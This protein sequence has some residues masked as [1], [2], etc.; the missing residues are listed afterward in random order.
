L[1]LGPQAGV[2]GLHLIAV[3]IDTDVPEEVA[4]IRSVLPGSP[5]AKRGAKGETQF[6]LAPATVVSRPYNDAGKRRML[7]LLCAGRQ[8]VMVPSIH[9][10]TGKPYV[11]ITPDA[12]D[13][14]DVA[15]LP[16][17]PADI[18]DRLAEA[19]KPFG[20]EPEAVRL[21]ERGDADL[22]GE[23]VH[24][25]LNDAALA[26]LDAWVPALQLHGCRQV[27]GKYKAVAHWRA[28]SSGRPLAQRATNLAIS[29]DGIKD[30]GENKG[31]TPLDLVMAACGA[32]LDTAFTWLQDRVAPAK[33]II[34]T[35]RPAPAATPQATPQPTP[36]A[37]KKGGN[38]KGLVLASVDGVTQDWSDLA[39]PATGEIDVPPP[40]TVIPAD[41]CM[42]AGLIGDVVSWMTACSPVPS[43]Q[44]NLSITLAFLGAI[45]GRRYESP[46]GA[47]TNL[48]TIGV[49]DSGF[50]KSFPMKCINSIEHAAS[51]S[52][53]FGPGGLK[54]D[55]A[56]RKLLETKNPVY[57]AVDEIGEL[58][59][60]ILNR[61]ASAHEVG[62]RE[63]LL[64]L[65]SAADDV[66]RGSEGAAEKAIPI[67]NPHLNLFGMS[68]PSAFWAAF[69]TANAENGLLP[70]I[71]I[72]D[73]GK[74]EPDE[75]TPTMDRRDVPH[76]IVK[77]LHATLDVRPTGNLAGVLNNG[78][79]RPITAVY[80]AGA[81]EMFV[82]IR[83][84]M[85]A[86]RRKSQGLEKLAYSRFAEHTIKL[87]LIYAIGCDPREP[88]ITVS[89]LT[90]A[91]SIV[92]HTTRTLIAGAIDRV[93]DNEY[94]AD[95]KR[96]LRIV[97]DAGPWGMT[98]DAMTR[99][100]AGS[101]DKRRLGDIVDQLAA[102]RDI[103]KY[104][105]SGPKG[106]RPGARVRAVIE[107]AEAV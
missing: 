13:A 85:K 84:E 31:Y 5:C 14:I 49:A 39:D 89:A 30:C 37:R 16:V 106:G 15:D 100:I 75:V 7:D 97:K 69:N 68:T 36:Q 93:A 20:H 42:P 74:D 32:D 26:N 58:F 62:L 52:R 12:L 44:L 23:S 11:W 90:W 87:A 2:N 43:P 60:K 86:L 3:D 72:F 57:V 81:E 70:R 25:S 18:A 95:Y 55:S 91:R 99:I 64:A 27:A 82:E 46:T 101:I 6:Y 41:L 77:A 53:F 66:Y 59:T 34:L 50:G 28:S 33:P 29:A 24:R 92:E 17:L 83:E 103:E 63:L 48:Y 22:D 21:G 79:V 10:T 88:A 71:L 9:P 76:S 61:K 45:F 19:L 56:L 51:L 35:A 40:S 54:S 104:V 80:A 8:T 78:P 38:L 107:V 1:P 67:Y 73:A 105:G 65:F 47:R 102:A 94:Q 98:V 4:A 96:V